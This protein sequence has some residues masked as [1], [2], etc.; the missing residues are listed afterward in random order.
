[1]KSKAINLLSL[2]PRNP[3]EF[4]DRV[5]EYAGVRFDTILQDR[6]KYN[7]FSIEHG[8]SLVFPGAVRI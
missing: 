4:Y 8:I 1:M 3:I 5:A 7:A 6:P 2:L